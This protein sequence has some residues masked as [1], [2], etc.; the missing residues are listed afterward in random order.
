MFPAI[1]LE[2]KERKLRS[3]NDLRGETIKTKG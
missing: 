2:K 1:N 3:E